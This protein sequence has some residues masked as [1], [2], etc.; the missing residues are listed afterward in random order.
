MNTNDAINN[1]NNTGEIVVISKA[2]NKKN[3]IY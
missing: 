3:K 2:R 1:I